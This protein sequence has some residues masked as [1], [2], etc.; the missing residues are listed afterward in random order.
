MGEFLLQDFDKR[1]Q[2]RTLIAQQPPMTT[3][4]QGQDQLLQPVLSHRQLEQNLALWAG[5]RLEGLVDDGGS[6]RHLLIDELAADRMSRGQMREGFATAQ[7]LQEQ[8]SP[9]PRAHLGRHAAI[10]AKR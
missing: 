8:V 5:G 3:Q 6:F 4:R 9:L 7:G 1:Q 2:H 10:T